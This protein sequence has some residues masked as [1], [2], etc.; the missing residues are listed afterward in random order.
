MANQGCGFEPDNEPEVQPGEAGLRCTKQQFLFSSW[1]GLGSLTASMFQLLL[2]WS[3]SGD[4]VR[5][6]STSGEL[7]GGGVSTAEGLN[8]VFR[9]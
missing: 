6:V 8:W 5:R 9:E 2:N 4:A 1:P 3:S 7:G